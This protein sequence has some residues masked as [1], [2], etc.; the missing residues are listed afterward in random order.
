MSDNGRPDP[1]EEAWAE[2]QKRLEEGQRALGRAWRRER[3]AQDRSRGRQPETDNSKRASPPVPEL[4]SRA[5]PKANMQTEHIPSQ[6]TGARSSNDPYGVLLELS[7]GPKPHKE[8]HA[9]IPRALMAT[10]QYG[11][12]NAIALRV[13]GGLFLYCNRKTGTA[14]PGHEHLMK[15]LGMLDTPNNC[16]QISRGIAMLKAHG[17]AWIKSP[18]YPGH[19]AEYFI[20]RNQ[21]Q[22][23]FIL[24]LNGGQSA[25][26]K[27]EDSERP[28]LGEKQ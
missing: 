24:S 9:R 27:M 23:D 20:A 28:P 13:C 10:P 15:R 7:H 6:A 22:V 1:I 11:R 21:Q 3:E 25:S 4:K 8:P 5:A 17:I 18:A 19:A 2:E 16:K 14:R 12:L 26:P